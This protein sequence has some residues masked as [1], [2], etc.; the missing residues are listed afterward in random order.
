MIPGDR[1]QTRPQVDEDR[2]VALGRRTR[3]SVA[4]PPKSRVSTASYTQTIWFAGGTL[5]RKRPD[6]ELRDMPSITSCRLARLPQYL[7]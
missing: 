6:P 3:S 4:A 7:A 1:T 2:P 5:V